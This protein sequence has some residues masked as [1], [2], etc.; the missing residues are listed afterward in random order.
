MHYCKIID[1]SAGN[2]VRN[3]I[4]VYRK[5]DNVLGMY[6]TVTE[7][8]YVNSGSGSFIKCNNVDYLTSENNLVSKKDHTLYAIWKSNT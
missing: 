4:P 2:V 8:L 3:L 5:S 6:D 1:K 7:T